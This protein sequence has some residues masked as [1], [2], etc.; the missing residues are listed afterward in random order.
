MVVNGKET[1]WKPQKQHLQQVS[2]FRILNNTPVPSNLKF[3]QKLETTAVWQ[4]TKTLSF[5][6]I[7]MEKERELIPDLQ[8]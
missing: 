8:V 5:I 6:K 2:K 3:P 4:K 1:L 7:I